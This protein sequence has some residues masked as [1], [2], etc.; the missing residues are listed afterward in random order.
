M[1]TLANLLLLL[2]EMFDVTPARLDAIRNGSDGKPARSPLRAFEPHV[3]GH[4][5]LRTAA[6]YRLRYG[7]PVG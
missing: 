2:C 3:P 6:V 7:W 4:D 1:N 5:S